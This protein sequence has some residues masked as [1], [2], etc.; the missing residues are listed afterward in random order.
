MTGTSITPSRS[1][2]NKPSDLLSCALCEQGLSAPPVQ[3]LENNDC[4]S[5]PK[6]VG[7]IASTFLIPEPGISE[8]LS[9][10]V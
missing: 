9:A 8:P 3:E 1:Q 7:L 4:G 6:K 5:S 10:A 2:L